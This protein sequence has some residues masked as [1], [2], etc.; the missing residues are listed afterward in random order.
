MEEKKIDYL[1]N[2]PVRCEPCFKSAFYGTTI[3]NK[4]KIYKNVLV[5]EPVFPTNLPVLLF[6]RDLTAK[7]GVY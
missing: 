2:K 7:S 6:Q 1:L 3:F 4:D 5:I